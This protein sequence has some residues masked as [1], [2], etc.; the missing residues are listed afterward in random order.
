M[1]VCYSVIPG[2]AMIFK[3]GDWLEGAGIVSEPD[4]ARLDCTD[5]VWMVPGTHDEAN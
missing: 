3:Y 1:T 2:D 5:C 4:W